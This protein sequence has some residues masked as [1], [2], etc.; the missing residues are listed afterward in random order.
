V[1]QFRYFDLNPVSLKDR[2]FFIKIGDFA[3]FFRQILF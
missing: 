2:V 3:S 1:Q